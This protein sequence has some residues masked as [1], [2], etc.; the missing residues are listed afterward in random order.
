MINLST[1]QLSNIR[2]LIVSSLFLSLTACASFSGQSPDNDED[3]RDNEFLND[4]YSLLYQAVSGLRFSDDLLLVKSE[5]DAVKNVEENIADT[6]DTM[7]GELEQL[8]EDYPAVDIER[9]PLPEIEVKK[10]SAVSKD[11][12]LSFAPLVGR[13]GAAF[14]RTLLL[15]NSGALN[16]TSFLCKVMAEK[17]PDEQLRKFLEQCEQRFSD[18]YDEVVVLLNKEYFIDDTFRPES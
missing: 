9:S 7:R 2:K 4:G 3:S 1:T 14:E 12:L 5:S 16:Q 18:L 8:A 6:A 17:E 13:S 10:R 15:S 11:R